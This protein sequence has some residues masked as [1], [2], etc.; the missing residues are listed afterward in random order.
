MFQFSNL[1]IDLVL[2]SDF[3]PGGYWGSRLR[4][5]YGRVLKEGLCDH[6]HIND[7][8]ECPRFRE[9]GFPRLFQPVRTPEESRLADAPLKHK[10]DL[11]R[12]FVIDPPPV[13]EREYKQ[14]EIVTVGFISLGP[15]CE[16]IAYPILAFERFEQTG[17]PGRSEYLAKFS[18]AAVRDLLAGGCSLYNPGSIGGAIGSAITRDIADYARE[19][20]A[21]RSSAELE[22]EFITPVTV[23]NSNA[24]RRDP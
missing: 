22:I 3:A 16:A 4:G 2:E 12:P 13:A 20:W 19:G 1:Q 14:S 11:P 6:Q 10:V 23:V 24:R 5:G 7:C 17:V 8:R 18:L 21:R 15:L 9:C